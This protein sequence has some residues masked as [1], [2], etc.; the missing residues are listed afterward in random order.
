MVNL[1][2]VGEMSRGGLRA[3]ASTRRVGVCPKETVEEPS[4]NTKS[5]C[6][7]FHNPHCCQPYIRTYV[8]AQVHVLHE[9]TYALLQFYSKNFSKS[10]ISLNIPIMLIPALCK[11]ICA[12]FRGFSV[13]FCINE[14]KVISYQL[15]LRMFRLNAP[16]ANDWSIQSKCRQ[17]IFQAQVGT[18]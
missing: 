15:E 18:R 14:E 7:F 17:V 12:N 1:S 6:N 16:F 3:V 4:N 10:N 2:S 5:F 13:G 9:N 8:R 11:D